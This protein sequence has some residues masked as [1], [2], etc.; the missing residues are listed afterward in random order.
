MKSLPFSPAPPLLAW[1]QKPGLYAMVNGFL[2]LSQVTPFLMILMRPRPP[3]KT[4][5]NQVHAAVHMGLMVL[6]GLHSKADNLKRW[7]TKRRWQEQHGGQSM[8]LGS[9]ASLSSPRL[10]FFVY[11]MVRPS[12]GHEEFK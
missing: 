6:V 9:V 12:L 1:P 3:S 11:N 5:S 4:V 7:E 8:R 10:N 2:F